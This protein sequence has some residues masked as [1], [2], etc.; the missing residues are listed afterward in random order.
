MPCRL[1]VMPEVPTVQVVPLPE[2][3]RAPPSP[4]TMNLSE[5]VPELHAAA[6]RLAVV[7]ELLA[8]QLMPSGEVRMAPPFPTA[9]K[10]AEPVPGEPKATPFSCAVVP[11]LLI[12]HVAPS[13][14]VTMAPP[15]PTATIKP[16]P[17]AAPRS[18]CPWGRGL[19]HCQA[20]RVPAEAASA[21]T[22]RANSGTS[23]TVTRLLIRI[24]NVPP[25]VAE[26]S[27]TFSGKYATYA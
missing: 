2:E 14:E 1:L 5:A 15:S 16:V 12:V 6:P 10:V 7:P 22:I 23:T 26:K 8:V 27:A 24:A 17:E 13:G 20:S 3:R 9:T 18:V 19:R 4:T 25:C 21:V 11:E